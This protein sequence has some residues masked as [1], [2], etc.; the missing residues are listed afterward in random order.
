MSEESKK[1]NEVTKVEETNTPVAAAPEKPRQKERPRFKTRAT[2][3]GLELSVL[4]PGVSAENLSVHVEDRLLTLKARRNSVDYPS[5]GD[6]AEEARDYELGLKLHQDLD[7]E[8]ISAKHQNGIL[9]LTLNK[10]AEIAK[11][12]IDILAN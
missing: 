5:Y 9:T 6:Q 8:Q 10:R 11:R 1:N 7:P 12:Q 4:L 3:R 2:E